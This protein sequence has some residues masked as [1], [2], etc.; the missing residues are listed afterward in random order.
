MSDATYIRWATD[1]INVPD[2]VVKKVWSGD[3][4]T[5]YEIDRWFLKIGGSLSPECERVRWLNGRLP[6]PEVVAFGTL[7]GKDALVTSAVKG[8]SLAKLKRLLPVGDI[9]EMLAFALR[10]FHEADAGDCPFKA[11][12]SGD[13][14][15]HGDACLPNIIF[16]NDGTLSGFVDLG[17]M[18]VGDIEVDLSAAVWSLQYNLGPGH[19]LAFLRAY[20]RTDATN[21]DVDRL[22]TMYANGI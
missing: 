15:V 4:S 22:W 10:A 11:V 12:I 2:P 14:L 20:G 18:G 5:V 13:V 6:V 21:D 3:N 8:E 1:K 19:G 7:E 9:V 16:R 17:E